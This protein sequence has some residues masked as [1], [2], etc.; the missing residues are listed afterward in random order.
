[1]ARRLAALAVAGCPASAWFDTGHML[2]AEMAKMQ[3]PQQHVAGAGKC[4][5]TG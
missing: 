2:V 3:L 5:G 1:M 4:G